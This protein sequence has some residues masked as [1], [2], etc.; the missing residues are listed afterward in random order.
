MQHFYILIKTFIFLHVGRLMFSQWCIGLFGRT[1]SISAPL[2]SWRQEVRVS[3]CARVVTEKTKNFWKCLCTTK[4]IMTQLIIKHGHK[5]IWEAIDPPA[6]IMRLGCMVR[7]EK[8]W[9]KG[10]KLYYKAWGIKSNKV[11][12]S[13]NK[14]FLT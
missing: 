10:S 4:M 1:A 5:W 7:D 13:I 14:R 3:V 6:L 11:W 12:E 2:Y 8:L 9:I